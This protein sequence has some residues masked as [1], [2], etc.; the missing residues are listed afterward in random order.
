[1]RMAQGRVVGLD[2][3]A[4]MLAC[5]C[6]GLDRATAID[7]FPAVEAGLMSTLQQNT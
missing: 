4:W 7:L 6:T 1:M 3:N 5:E 2:L